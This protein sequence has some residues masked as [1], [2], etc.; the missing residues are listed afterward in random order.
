MRV[1]ISAI[2][3]CGALFA[4][5]SAAA[6]GFG[7]GHE[8]VQGNPLFFVPVGA[9]VFFTGYDLAMAVQD[10]PTEQAVAILEVGA[11]LPQFLLATSFALANARGEPSLE[12]TVFAVW[13]GALLT[14]GTVT[15]ALGSPRA[16]APT[17]ADPAPDHPH[18]SFAPSML[19]DGT[20]ALVPGILAVG[21]F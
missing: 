10:E 6:S 1:S 18:I 16:A 7:I 17:P 4:S 3:V 15:W 11:T 20:R 2:A 19:G 12:S 9:D 13:T 14:H 8:V 5:R 21:T